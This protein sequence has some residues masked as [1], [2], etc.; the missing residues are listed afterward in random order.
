MSTF[1]TFGIYLHEG[2]FVRRIFI[3]LRLSPRI[4]PFHMWQKS[5]QTRVVPTFC[6]M[7]KLSIHSIEPYIKPF[8]PFLSQPLFPMLLESKAKIRIG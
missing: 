1:A 5:N 7:P 4:L 6:T 8:E 2:G 3:R